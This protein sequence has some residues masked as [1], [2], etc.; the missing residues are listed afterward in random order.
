MGTILFKQLLLAAAITCIAFMARA[1]VT[2]SLLADPESGRVLLRE[3]DCGKA[4]TPASTFKVPLAVMGFDA[5]I[6]VDDAHPAWDFQPGFPNWV[7]A[8][9]TTVTPRYWL[10]KSVVWYSQEL[11][12][13]LGMEKFRGY[14]EAFGYGNKDV[15]G[16]PGKNDGLTQSWLRSSLKVTPDE[17]AVFLGKFINRSLPV[18]EKAMDL[19]ESA[20]PKVD[21][22][23]RW[24][25]YGKTGTS[26][27]STVDGSADPQKRQLGWYVGWAE[28]DGVK[29][30]F[31]RLIED[32]TRQKTFAGTRA[33]EAALEWLP[34]QLRKLKAL[35]SGSTQP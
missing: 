16:N 5:G 17:Q 22:D 20:M 21:L 28:D 14:V 25:V 31:V 11:T 24:V 23:G 15:T 18:S 12:R 1:D 34:G 35:K 4:V 33:K 13:K 6:L 26:F 19:A 9:K 3:G 29:V 7:E 27:R 2:C 8:W 30:I 32:E 10:E